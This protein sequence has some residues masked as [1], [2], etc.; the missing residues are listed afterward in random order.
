MRAGSDAT[1]PQVRSLVRHARDEVDIVST[2]LATHA[3]GGPAP[4]TGACPPV[5]TGRCRACACQAERMPPRPPP[6][7]CGTP[8]PR[9]RAEG[10]PAR[11]G[12]RRRRGDVG[13][14]D[15][16]RLQR[17]RR[18]AQQLVR[19]GGHRPRRA[20]RPRLRLLAPPRG[21]A[22]PRRRH[23][24]QRLPAL[25]GVGP[26]RA[27]ARRLRRRRARALR[28]DP[29]PV[30]RRGAWSPSSRCTTSPTRGG[31]ARSSGCGRARPTSSPATWRGSCRRWRRTAGAG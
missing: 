23:R 31:W 7:P 5:R 21:G 8:A 26:A 30:R 10:E 29:L 24:L 11:R 25:G 3:L 19:L 14:P 12:L 20:L 1:E 16:G 28:R 22:R 6:T 2:A 17:R 15:R 18:A 9:R 4:L 27:P 13:L